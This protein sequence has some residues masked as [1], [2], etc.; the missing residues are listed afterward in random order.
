MR[1][2]RDTHFIP[3]PSNGRMRGYDIPFCQFMVENRQARLPIPPNLKKSVSRWIRRVVHCK[4]NTW[5]MVP[6]LG[7]Y[8]GENE[9]ASQRMD[10]NAPI[11]DRLSKMERAAP[12]KMIDGRGYQCSNCGQAVKNGAGSTNQND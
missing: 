10:T 4:K 12:I 6:P 2:P 1:V 7:E 9:K 3:H 8:V 11:V 5:T